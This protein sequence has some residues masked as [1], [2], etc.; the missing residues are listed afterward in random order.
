MSE[1]IEFKMLDY[2]CIDKDVVTF[3]LEDGSIVKIKVDIDRAGVAT[4]YTNPDGTPHYLINASIKVKVI[5]SSKR[6]SIEKR[7]IKSSDD[8]PSHIR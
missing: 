6:F 4:N 3:R 7:Q 8:I 2:E 1:K 5:P